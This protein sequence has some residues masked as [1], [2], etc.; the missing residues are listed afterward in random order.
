MKDEMLDKKAF[1]RRIRAAREDKHW[2]REAVAEKVEL[3]VNTMADIER[4]KSGTRLENFVRLCRLLELDADYVLFGNAPDDARRITELLRGRDP[5]TIRV[6]EQTVEALLR[7]LDG[8][9]SA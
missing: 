6:V 8:K 2:T 3:S 5:E 7:A 9:G 1:G 4:G